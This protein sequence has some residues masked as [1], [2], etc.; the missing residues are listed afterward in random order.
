M[1]TKKQSLKESIYNLLIGY[2]ISFISL[3]LIFPLVGIE[4]SFG[5]NMLI[6]VYFSVL[7]IARS[8]FLR[9]FFNRKNKN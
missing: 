2:A 9:R 1:Q 3:F 5:K 8:Y 4:S 7:S 6:T